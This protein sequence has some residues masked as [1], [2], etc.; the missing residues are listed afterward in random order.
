VSVSP[1][2]FEL[3]SRV[4][5]AP[6][7][8]S[9]QEQMEMAPEVYNFVR[10]RQYE[11][12]R[13]RKAANFL[14]TA[15]LLG[16]AAYA[17]HKYLK[18]RENNTGDR[19]IGVDFTDGGPRRPDSG[20]SG[21]GSGPSSGLDDS[22]WSKV[23]PPIPRSPKGGPSGGSD[24]APIPKTVVVDDS[25]GNRRGGEFV[26]NVSIEV[27]DTPERLETYFRDVDDPRLKRVPQ[28]DVDFDRDDRGP[29]RKRVED[30]IQNKKFERFVPYSAIPL[31]GGGML[32]QGMDAVKIMGGADPASLGSVYGH[33]I[34]Q[35][36]TDLANRGLTSA[37][38]HIPYVG[39]GT[40]EAVK[41]VGQG[42]ARQGNAFHSLGNAISHTPF[43]GGWLSDTASAATHLPPFEVMGNAF[44]AAG[45]AIQTGTPEL[46]LGG[47]GVAG[48]TAGIGMGRA[49][50]QAQKDL[51]RGRKD[52]EQSKR[53]LGN[54]GRFLKAFGDRLTGRGLNLYEDHPQQPGGQERNT[55]S[56]TI[57]GSDRR[58]PGGPAGLGAQV[59]SQDIFL[60]GP[61]DQYYDATKYWRGDF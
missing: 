19:T 38:D 53:T 4:T 33:P 60:D 32:H 3:Y 31:A 41:G 42:L 55:P 56:M 20:P 8:R 50:L 2:D 7:P 22:I 29:I 25:V 17:G 26:N 5:G 1:A 12:S 9:P 45:H 35:T 28:K 34:G 57:Q 18:N 6:M 54:A 40:V 21:L 43:I 36:V 48:A 61:R 58:L 24:A 13:L 59:E 39:H 46:I 49:A 51:R 52:I 16:G 14:G 23:G 30:Y 15:A 27:D 11:P 47:L 10:E 37:V 44:D